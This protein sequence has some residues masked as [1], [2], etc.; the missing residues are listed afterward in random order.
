MSCWIVESFCIASP[1]D[2]LGTQ[3]KPSKKLKNK[4]IVLKVILSVGSTTISIRSL[5]S[6]AIHIISIKREP[7]I[8]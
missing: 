5:V 6:Q 3:G 8:E 7:G 4:N 1:W 2:H